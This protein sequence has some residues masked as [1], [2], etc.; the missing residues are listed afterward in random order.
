VSPRSPAPAEGHY[1]DELAAYALDALHEDEAAALRRHLD[2]C[3]KCREHLRWLRPAVDLLPRTVP[4]VEPPPRLRKRL[5]ATVRS[6]SRE[7]ARADSVA[8]WRDWGAFLLRPAT[9][10]AAGVLLV[11]GALGG[12]LL[13]QPTGDRTSVVP[14][15]ANKDLAPVASGTLERQDG[16]AILHVEGM[17]ALAGDRVYETWVKRGGEVEPSS[18]FTL[19]RNRS[20][21][22]AIPGPLEGADAVLVTAE[23]RGGSSQPTSRPVLQASLD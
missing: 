22:A 16:S 20:G 3:E 8:G 4:Q 23:P 10:V 7:A 5:M 6:E 12:Y 14:V 15:Q 11:A 17:P 9:A 21:D 2:G 18:L 19:R 13:H 1:R